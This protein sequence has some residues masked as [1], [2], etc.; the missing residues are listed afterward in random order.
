M[1][2]GVVVACSKAKSEAP[3]TVKSSTPPVA[4]VVP[5]VVETLPE[6]STVVTHPETLPK[7]EVQ[8]VAA[9]GLLPKGAVLSTDRKTLYVTNFGELSNKKNVTIYDAETLEPKGQIDVPH[10]VVEGVASPDD[11][12]LYLSS[13]WGH[14]VIFVD[15]ATKAVTHEVKTGNH[16]KIVVASKDGKSVFAANWSGESITQIDTGTATN[17][18]TLKVGK[19]PR[20]LVVSEKNVVYAANFYD[21]SIDV[22]EGAELDQKHRIK[23]CK[24]PRHLA[25]SPDDKTLYISCLFNSE[26][27][28]M[29]LATEKVTHK[30]TVGASPKSIA[31]SPDG[32]YVYSAEYGLTR[33]VSVVDTRDWTV[34]VFAVPGMDRG[35]GI[36]VNADGEHAIVTG[37]YDSHVYKL[38]FEGAGGHPDEAKKKIATWLGRPFSKDPGDGQ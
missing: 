37:W 38:G 15:V 16:P 28:A 4:P 2:L 29:D 17:V 19:N 6:A 12:T 36:A 13:F 8:E 26:I 30:A 5:V 20:G 1:T 9:T 22:F 14:S 21:E 3:P 35:S 23:V 10:V 7:L 24:C 34:K 27:H 33:S 32:R 31:V 18:R 25:L 11:K